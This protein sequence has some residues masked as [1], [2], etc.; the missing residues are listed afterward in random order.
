MLEVEMHKRL[1]LAFSCLIFAGLGFFIGAL[2]QRGIRSTAIILC[3]VVAM[4]YW[5]ALLAAQAF[6]SGGMVAPWLGIWAPN[7]FFAGV[8]YFCYRRYA[9]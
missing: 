2:S 4:I 6:A 7:F 9:R 1:S 3:L 5:L 8:A